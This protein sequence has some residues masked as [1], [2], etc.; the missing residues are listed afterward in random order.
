MNN[1]T[2]WKATFILLLASGAAIAPMAS[3]AAEPAKD[4]QETKDSKDAKDSKDS[5]DAAGPAR[6]Y[7]TITKLDEKAKTFTIDEQTYAITGET[8]MTKDD[9]DAT[10]KDAVVGE[11]AR[12]TYTKS[13]E[14]KLS[15]TK[16]RFGKKAG[17]K[18]G[19]KK[20]EKDKQKEPAA[21]P[22]K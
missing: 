5:K 3:R 22:A 21:E 9:K 12:G 19:G 2:I 16:V 10:L 6:F 20:K 14:G 4:K 7:G 1:T 17:G 8:K 15:V 13:S 18:A 11:P